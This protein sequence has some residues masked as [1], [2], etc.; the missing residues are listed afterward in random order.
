MTD[1]E[2]IK[3]VDHLIAPLGFKRKGALWNRESDSVV[4]VID[5]Q[6]N[7]AGDA[8]TINAGVL[9]I[10]AYEEVWGA[11][12]PE[13][14]EEPFCI[15]RA[16]V[17]EIVGEHDLWWSLSDSQTPEDVIAVIEAHVLPFL[18]KWQTIEAMEIFLERESGRQPLPKIYLAILKSLRGDKPG[19]CAVLKHVREKAL[20]DWKNRAAEIAGRLGCDVHH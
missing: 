11:K 9:H 12:P 3:C 15:V 4:E 6:I 10:D 2:I 16:R 5:I 8:A 1:K 19:A 13:F 14:I 18:D 20:G 7:K 17:G